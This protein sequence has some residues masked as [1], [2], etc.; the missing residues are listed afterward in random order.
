MKLPKAKTIA[1]FKILR[2]VE[3]Q[4]IDLGEFEVS[5]P[6]DNSVAF[7]DGVGGIMTLTLHPDGE[8]VEAYA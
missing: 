1:Q 2:H 7:A 4:A 8:V 3:E 5:F 6:T